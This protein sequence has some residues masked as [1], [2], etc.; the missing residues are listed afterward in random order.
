VRK[1]PWGFRSDPGCDLL[2]SRAP[3]GRR[4]RRKPTGKRARNAKRP[5]AD[6]SGPSVNFLGGGF[7]GNPA[8]S[9]DQTLFGSALFLDFGLRAS[10]IS[11][12][13][14][15][16]PFGPSRRF[17]RFTEFC[18]DFGDPKTTHTFVRVFFESATSTCRCTVRSA[19]RGAKMRS[20]PCDSTTCDDTSDAEHR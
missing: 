16:V 4:D 3:G 18:A 8:S 6:L 15:R 1:G 14:V 19:L 2:K 7:R 5:A 13:V 10:R 20:T 17:G 9:P 11:S 12:C